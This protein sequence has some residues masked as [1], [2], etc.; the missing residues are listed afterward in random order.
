MSSGIWRRATLAVLLV[1]TLVGTSACVAYSDP[2][3]R[4]GRHSYRDDGW[5]Y[6]KGGYDGRHNAPRG[7]DGRYNYR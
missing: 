3:Y 6:S 5:R 7:Y 1:T 2:Y 4:D